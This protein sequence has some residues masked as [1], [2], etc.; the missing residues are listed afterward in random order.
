MYVHQRYYVEWNV[1]CAHI[2][3]TQIPIVIY[4]ALKNPPSAPPKKRES[5]ARYKNGKVYVCVCV[6]VK[7]REKE[8]LFEEK[9]FQK[10]F[11]P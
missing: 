6:Y 2:Y 5:S 3:G 11:S 1:V 7:E 8:K 10:N 4:G 9:I